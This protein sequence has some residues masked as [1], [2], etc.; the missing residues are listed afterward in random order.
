MSFVHL[1]SHTEYSLLDGCNRITEYVARV[2]ELGMNAAAITDHGVMYGV[3]DFYRECKAQGIRPILGCEVY[4]APGSRFDREFSRGEE[5]YHH[6]ILLAENN[7]GYQNL[8]KLV[9]I[10]YVEGFYSKPRVDMEVLEQYSEGLICSSA[11]I[12]GAVPKHILHGEYEEAKALA[13]HFQEIYG[14]GNFYL[15]LQDHG[16]KEQHLVNQELVRMSRETGIPLICTNDAHYTRRE[17]AG[18]QDVLM[19][20]Q[21]GKN[22]DDEKRMSFDSQ[23]FYVKS[24]EEMAALFPY[25]PE[26]LENTQKIA[27][28][29]NVEI[30]FGES[31]LPHF[32]TPDGYDSWTYLN[33]LCYEGLERRYGSGAEELKPRLEYEL[34]TIRNMGYVDYFLI[35]WDFINYARSNGIAV[36]PGRGSAAGSLVS[37]TT[38]IT[39]ID[40]IRYGLIFERF[41]NPERVSM[42]DIDVDFID[43][44]RGEVIEYVIEKYGAECVTQIVTFGTL[45]AKSAI[46]DVARVMGLPVS[47]GENLAKMLTGKERDLDEALKLNQDLTNLYSTDPEVKT[48]VDTARRIEGLPRNIGIHAAGVVIA[49][50]PM[51]EYVP[52]VRGGKDKSVLT[53]FT[54]TTIE[55]LGLL[56]MDFLGLS[57]LSIIDNTLK[58][59][60]A[61]YGVDLDM[62]AIDYDDKKVFRLIADGKTEGV[63]Q[64]EQDGMTSFMVELE[65]ESLEDVIAGISLYRPGPMDFIPNY[66]RGK[67]DRGSIVYDCPQLE[68][69]LAPTYGCIVYQEQV[70]QIVREL[71]GY[72]MGQSDNVRRAMSKKKQE[73]MA[74][75]R[76]NFVYGNAEAG[77]PGCIANGISEAVANKIYDDMTDFA[78]YAF[79]KSHAAAYAVVAYQTAYLKCYYPVEFMAA[80]M[81]SEMGNSVKIAKYVAACKTMGIEVLPPHVN[82]SGG[83]FTATKEGQ[84]RHGLYAV[85]GIGVGVADAM[86]A[87]R[88]LNGRFTILDAFLNRCCGHGLNKKAVDCLI[89]AGALDGLGDNRN[90]MCIMAPN[91]METI[92]KKAKSTIAGQLSLFDLASDDQKKVLEA[93]KAQVD[94]FPREE[95][96]AYE[97]EVIGVYVSGHPLEDYVQLLQERTSAKAEDFYLQEAEE[98]DGESVGQASLRD[99]ASVI[100]GGMIS[101]MRKLTTKKGDEMA[102]LKL[103]DL[104]GIVEVVVFPQAY[105]KH[106]EF[107][108]PS[109]KLFIEGKVQINDEKNASLIGNKIYPM[110]AQATEPTTQK[111]LWLRFANTG[112]FDQGRPIISN[113]LPEGAGVDKVIAFIADEKKQVVLKKNCDLGQHGLMEAFGIVLGNDNVKLV[114]KPIENREQTH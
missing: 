107:L 80:L 46:K 31:K 43:T 47:F 65:P 84:I 86:I 56:K 113:M 64:L 110:V 93:P 29:C 36:G 32:D 58:A 74:K 24:E 37:Y 38:G 62:D 7:Q 91:M 21:T 40:P 25:A 28:R 77:V 48:V 57:T 12:A 42:P 98:S 9:S 68:P 35:V 2:K 70:M 20:I 85:K 11:C 50:R 60:K 41:L 61:N 23:E 75:E 73:V 99:G 63:F 106:K 105:Y 54:M 22:L 14:E 100:I 3:I 92:S 82:E 10:G 67:K 13:L 26:A 52:L 90:Q 88:E 104:S 71:A 15:E 101:D 76:Q 17:D 59:V 96:L 114:E 81:T 5:R 45:K 79:N 49:Q 94:E 30:V 66:I 95:L 4:V 39:N 55:Q 83:N 19:C 44:R 53:Q 27:D 51:D 109:A 72:S 78:K 112:A 69:I 103:E 97:K 1:H 6:L 111:V 108:T 33:K 8:I 89:K 16:L 18:I 87:D 34:Q 102:T